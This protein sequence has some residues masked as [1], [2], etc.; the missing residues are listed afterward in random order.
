M[1]DFR[2]TYWG[3]TAL[4]RLF[5][6]DGDLLYIG[7]A[8]DPQQRWER[9]RQI[10]DWWPQVARKTVEWHATRLE[11]AAAEEAAI[12]HERPRYNRT[13]SVAP[14]ARRKHGEG[15]RGY[16]IKDQSK[17]VSVETFSATAVRDN[18]F[19]ISEITRY[20]RKELGEIPITFV[21]FRGKPRVAFV[22]A[23]VAEWAEAHAAE[24]CAAYRAAH[25]EE[26]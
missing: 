7:I 18:I 15:P 8:N 16:V 5:D 4:Y 11:A 9:H 13:H 2:T 12:Q 20:A 21:E 23:W 10:K 24:L 22:P 19:W 25:S 26:S 6:G 14:A 17:R 3:R 1:D